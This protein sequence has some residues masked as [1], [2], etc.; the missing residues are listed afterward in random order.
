MTPLPHDRNPDTLLWAAHAD[1]QAFW[2]ALHL[3]DDGQ[4]LVTRLER[5]GY[6]RTLALRIAG[7]REGAS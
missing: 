5:R 2:H 1:H 7:W 6:A 3:D 4:R